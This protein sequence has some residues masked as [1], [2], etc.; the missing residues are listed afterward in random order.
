MLSKGKASLA[1][2]KAKQE[3]SEALSRATVGQDMGVLTSALEEAVSKN[4][5]KDLVEKGEKR[6][7]ALQEEAARKEAEDALAKAAEA[8]DIAGLEAAIAKAQAAK[9][10]KKAI[11]VQHMLR[12]CRSFGA[13]AV[14]QALAL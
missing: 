13:R 10:P 1:E 11:V 2:A 4:V 9:V 8:E 5:S 6:L 14:F 12:Y 3:A 7:A